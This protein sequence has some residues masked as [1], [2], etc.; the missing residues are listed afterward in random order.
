MAELSEFDTNV[1]QAVKNAASDP[2]YYQ[3]SPRWFPQLD[4]ND[5]T[6]KSKEE[7]LAMLARAVDRSPEMRGILPDGVEFKQ[8]EVGN[9]FQ[10]SVT[11]DYRKSQL[12][13]MAANVGLSYFTVSGDLAS[14]NFSSLQQ[15]NLDNR[16]LYRATQSKVK[17]GVEQMVEGWMNWWKIKD[18]DIERRLEKTTIRYIMPPFEYID[19]VKAA[20]ADKELM[21]MGA[22]ALSLIIEALGE[23]PDAIFRQ[24][25]EDEMKRRQYYEEAGIPFPGDM[26][27]LTN[28]EEDDKV[29]SAED[30]D[31]DDDK[32]SGKNS[33]E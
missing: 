6:G 19:R 4:P 29:K 11:K 20:Q 17:E 16:A 23:D 33:D 14:A 15:G 7:V 27:G 25:A 5:T 24:Q 21:D 10:G 18:R 30:E 26:N 13:R 8:N 3:V 28:G 31:D 2:G 1:A 9:V 32:E 22:T 12:S